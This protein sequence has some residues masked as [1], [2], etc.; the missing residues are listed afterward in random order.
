MR[1]SCISS[2]YLIFSPCT[3]QIIASPADLIK[4]RMQ[5]SF[6]HPKLMESQASPYK[7]IPD[8]FLRIVRAEGVKGEF[9]WLG[10][11]ALTQVNSS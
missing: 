3:G 7:S 11:V 6:Q 1:V 2:F 8:A 10:T 9:G 4:V 5:A